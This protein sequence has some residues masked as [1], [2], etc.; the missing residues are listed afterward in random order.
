M[1]SPAAADLLARTEIAVKSYN[2]TDNST[3][4]NYTEVVTTDIKL[5]WDLDFTNQIIAGSVEHVVVVIKDGT[6][7]VNFDSSDIHVNGNVL[8]DEEVVQHTVHER[9]PMLGSKISVIIPSAKQYEGAR[10]TVRF[11]YY[12]TAAASAVQ[13]LPASATKGGKHPYVFTQCQAIHARS[14]MPCMDSPAVKTPYLAVVTAPKWCTVLMSALADSA[15]VKD[16]DD[17]RSKFVWVQ[18]VPTPAYLIALAAGNLAFRDIS[19]RVRVWSEPEVVDAAHFEFSE[20]EEFLK[21]AEELTCP[22]V[23]TRYDVLCLPP[24]FPYG[25]MVRAILNI[26][27]LFCLCTWDCGLRVLFLN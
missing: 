27:G 15:T 17:T 11:Q 19:D 26:N 6:K 4:S 7:T 22:Y 16:F 20:T 10:F 14:L 2:K 25:G 23:W 3:Q 1:Q 13:W 24:S 12:I 18:P 5:E 8:I 21:A 9:N